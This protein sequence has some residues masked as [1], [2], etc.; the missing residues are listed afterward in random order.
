[1]APSPRSASILII[2]DEILSGEVGDEN[3]SYL[4]RHLTAIGVRVVGMRVVPDRMSA[5][6]NGLK[7]ASAE[8]DA[9]FVSGG[10]GPTHDD[11]TRQAVAEAMGRGC[12]RHAE[13]EA[14]LRSGYGSG[15]TTAELSMAD[16]PGGARL[17]IGRRSG[18]FGFGVERVHVLPGV[19]VLLR[20]IFDHVIEDW[21]PAAYYR[22][23]M[24]TRFREGN[25][26]DALRK[27][28]HEHPAVAIGSYPVRTP[29]GHRVKIVLRTGDREALARARARVLELIDEGVGLVGVPP[30]PPP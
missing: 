28:Q 2:G 8:A 4:A 24:A 17:L 30:G 9:V 7:Q 21:E 27:I 11:L 23:E 26:A 5:I 16:L 12:E 14:R 6:V 13:A 25:L 1:M 10:I 29:E 19:P 3:A 15:L 22:E 18:A 20:E